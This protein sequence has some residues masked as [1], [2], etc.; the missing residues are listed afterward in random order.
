ME[1]T[2]GHEGVVRGLC[3]GGRDVYGEG[4]LLWVLMCRE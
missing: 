1:S 3:G 4:R 2:V